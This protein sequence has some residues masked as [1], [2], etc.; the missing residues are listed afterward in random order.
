MTDQFELTIKRTIKAPIS[1]AFEAWL[2][3]DALAAFMKPAP[4]VDVPEATAEGVEGGKFKVVMRAGDK[5]LPHHGIYKSIRKYEELIFTWNSPFSE[6]ESEV[7]LQFREL[8]EKE[9]EI[10]LKHT[11][12]P[13][14]ESRGNHEGGWTKILAILEEHLS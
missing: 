11:G 14:E 4:G 2:N 10:T 7:N 6:T 12:L 3:A 9:T 5:E 13:S 1:Q 8:S